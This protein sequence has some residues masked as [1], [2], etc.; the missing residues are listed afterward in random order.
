MEICHIG[1]GGFANVYKVQSHETK[2]Y[3][4]VKSI[5]KEDLDEMKVHC[6]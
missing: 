3:F 5:A 6:L 1:E 2:E 4:A